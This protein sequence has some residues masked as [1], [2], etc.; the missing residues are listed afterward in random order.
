MSPKPSLSGLASALVAVV[1]FLLPAAA[2][3]AER[4]H[5]TS[6]VSAGQEYDTNI[7]NDEN[8][9]EGSW[10]WRFRP[11]L[12]YTRENDFG[13]VRGRAGVHARIYT[14]DS[15]L[16]GVDR[17][18]LFDVERK[19]TPRFSLFSTG[20]LDRFEQRDEI[21]DGDETLRS[22]RP[23]LDQMQGQAGFRYSLSPVSQLTGSA[24]Y[25]EADYDDEPLGSP[26]DRR[27]YDVHGLSL[28]YGRA[29]SSTDR[30]DF[31]VAYSDIEFEDLG[32]GSLDEEIW[33][34]IAA[35][36][37]TWTPS[38]KSTLSL[39]AR[40]IESNQIGVT[41]RN[42]GFV[43]GL[44]LERKF[45][46]STLSVS[47]D[48]ET[49]P[50]TGSSSSVDIDHVR[51][52]LV[53]RINSRVKASFNAGWRHYKSAA[54]RLA[55]SGGFQLPGTGG[56]PSGTIPGQIILFPVCLETTTIDND[57]DTQLATLGLRVDWQARKRL[58]T[59][60]MVEWRNQDADGRRN[61]E[62]YDKVRVLFGF[63]YLYD[64]DL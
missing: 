32:G 50:S 15:D 40:R 30:M 34:G 33:S 36:S 24:S 60:A 49:R 14:E 38:L 55:L 28:S 21:S 29:F 59:Y 56:C 22:G 58:G 9:E 10:L 64:T 3:A 25:F 8:H 26:D 17:F 44:D 27:D 39:G 47:Y 7:Y 16:N 54:D 18:A 45:A 13:H 48:R 63:R 31:T 43:G 37:R 53:R 62:D 2:G 46:R 52:R 23:D 41:D 12:E 1:C 4:S 51:M 57:L 6:T 5:L 19:L 11:E 61:R 20:R 35:W 42:T